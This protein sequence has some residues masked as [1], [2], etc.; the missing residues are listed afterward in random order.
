MNLAGLEWQQNGTDTW[1]F[2]T[3]VR[4][5][6]RDVVAEIYCDD[7]EKDC[8]WVWFMVPPLYLC[9]K[10]PAHSLRGA[11]S[12]FYLAIEEAEEAVRGLLP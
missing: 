6:V 5:I 7:S 3:M 9:N 4:G 12:S 10:P 2:G 1:I 11:S 8:K